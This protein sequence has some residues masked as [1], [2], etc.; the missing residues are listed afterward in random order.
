MSPKP[1]SESSAQSTYV[2][3]AAAYEQGDLATALELSETVPADAPDA[4]D[5][6][7]LAAEC[8]A[9]LGEWETASLKATEILA[10]DPEWPTGYFIHGLAASRKGDLKTA[11]RAFERA[12]E[13]DA[14]LADAAFLRS[15]VADMEGHGA[16]ADQWLAKAHAAD[17]DYAAPRHIPTADVDTL[18]LHVVDEYDDQTLDTL[19]ESRFRIV[20]MPDRSELREGVFIEA[21]G[22]L[23]EFDP[24]GDPPTLSLTFYQ[25]NLERGAKDDAEIRERIRETLAEALG[26]LAES[27]EENADAEAND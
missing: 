20:D 2:R 1:P 15:A 8:L 27:V 16:E 10:L 18:L 9:E 19:D 6:A 4:L 17:S 7:A 22:N 12:W 25:R 3:A 26:L 21:W 11:A 14:T 24:S 23:T 13:M 5:A